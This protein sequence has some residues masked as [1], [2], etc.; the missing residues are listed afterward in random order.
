M[1]KTNTIK[2]KDIIPF[3]NELNLVVEEYCNRDEVY[4][5]CITELNYDGIK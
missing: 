1:E 3:H 2:K 5:K 4:D